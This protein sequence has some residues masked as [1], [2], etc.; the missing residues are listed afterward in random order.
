[1]LG[2]LTFAARTNIIIH[3][4]KI[5]V[6]ERIDKMHQNVN[7]LRKEPWEVALDR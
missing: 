2:T 3:L 6:F 5:H 4:L 1:M 7:E